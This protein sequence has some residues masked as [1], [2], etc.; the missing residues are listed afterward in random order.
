M[1]MK[2]ITSRDNPGYREL[3]ALA[4]DGRARRRAGR[5]LLDGP[6]LLEEALAAGIAPRR[7]VFAESAATALAAWC[8]RLPETLALL[9]PDRLFA[10]LTPVAHP[11]G[12][13]AE[14]DIPLMPAASPESMVLLENIQDPGNLGA[15]LRVA[16]AAGI[17]AA[18]LSGG[19]AEAWSPKCLR[20]GQG[21]HFRLD[22]AE[23]VDLRACIGGFA[24]PVYAASLGAERSLYALD[25][26]GRA[27]FLF[28]NE[29]AGLSAELC[30]A[31]TPFVIPMPGR[32]ES[33]NVATAAAICLFER[34]RQLGA[35][36]VRAR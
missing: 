13:L 21:A 11:A 6:H 5:T 10:S 28:G 19:C 32:M 29:G 2:S 7:L 33:L 18:R 8:D 16:A 22:I 4:S 26:R 3:L 27:G 30:E 31:S 35:A 9:L 25:L 17:V 24:A 20:G 36:T 15:I 23:Q 34:V 1:S 12:V 14:I